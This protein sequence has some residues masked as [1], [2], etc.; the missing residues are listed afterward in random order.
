MFARQDSATHA[1]ADSANIRCMHDRG[2][3][4][5]KFPTTLSHNYDLDHGPVAMC[6]KSRAKQVQL[7]HCNTHQLHNMLRL[8]LVFCLLA[9]LPKDLTIHSIV[10]ILSDV[11]TLKQ[12]QK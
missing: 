11:N 5:T 6:T 1:A 8:L 9:H 4:D 10:M 2:P 7:V 3:T 12:L